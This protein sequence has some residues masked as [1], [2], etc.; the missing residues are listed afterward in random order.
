[1]SEEEIILRQEAGVKS[2][3][4]DAPKA[5][6]GYQVGSLIVTNQ[7][8]V[9]ISKGK[10]ARTAL[11]VLAGPLAMMVLEKTVSKAKLDDLAK[12]EGSYSIPLQAITKVETARKWGGP[13]LRLDHPNLGGTPLHSY[14]FGTGFGVSKE[15]VQALDSAISS[16]PQPRVAEP[17]MTQPQALSST[18]PPVGG[19][20]FC[21]ECGQKIPEK[22]NFCPKCG[23]EQE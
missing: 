14:V 12:S 21:I 1:M 11:G 15:L 3:E 10:M 20:K 17:E 5:G 23:N 16:K 13:Y 2:Y 7:R 22:A 18:V 6:W 4:S 19:V 9:F 8:L